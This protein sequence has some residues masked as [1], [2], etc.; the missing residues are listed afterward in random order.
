MV[1]ACFFWKP[2]AQALEYLVDLVD[3]GPLAR[4]TAA[5]GASTASASA[6]SSAPQRCERTWRTNRSWK[7]RGFGRE[8]R[9]SSFLE[10]SKG[11]GLPGP[12]HRLVNIQ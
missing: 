2:I 12:A 5:S 7:W 4:P 3:L 9:G 10:S 6:R 1:P 8:N 11:R